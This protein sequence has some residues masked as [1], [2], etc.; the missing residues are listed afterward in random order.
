MALLSHHIMSSSDILWIG[1]WEDYG[2]ERTIRT[3]SHQHEKSETCQ[4][5]AWEPLQLAME[6][7]QAR[8]IKWGCDRPPHHFLAKTHFINVEKCVKWTCPVATAYFLLNLLQ[9]KVKGFFTKN[10]LSFTMQR[11][12]WQHKMIKILI[13][14]QWNMF[15]QLLW[16]SSGNIYCTRDSTTFLSEYCTCRVIILYV[17]TKQ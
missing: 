9:V 6:Q 17:C 1:L 3:N 11:C 10:Q 14:L 16:K 15:F 12:L 7:M 8:H 13:N 4:S 5:G 2:V